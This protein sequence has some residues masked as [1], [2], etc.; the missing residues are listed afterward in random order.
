MDPLAT[1]VIPTRDRPG[2]LEVALGSIAPQAAPAGAEVL[3]VVDGVDPGSARVARRHGARVLELPAGPGLNAARN[4]A[5]ESAAAPLLVFTDDDV[6]APEGWLAAILAGAGRYPDDDVFAGPIRAR[7]E[8]GRGPRGCGREAPPITALD[9]G[10]DDGEAP[11]AWGANMTI[12][13]AAFDRIGGFDPA[14]P[15]GGGDEEDW[16]RRYCAAGGRVRYLGAAGLDHRRAGEDAE[17]P[18]LARA[19]FHRGRLA[20]EH[21]ARRGEAPSPAREARTLAGCLVHT[22]CRRCA[23][24]VVLSA[25]AAGRI[26][27]AAGEHRSA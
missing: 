18:R 14:I 12:R 2:Y 7:L 11:R 15:S 27:A 19:A 13:R 3:V 26:R 22:V 6:R 23:M 20:R 10:P 4:A 1:V 9:L 16:Q 5:V 21:D 25:H 24:G 8:G 17:L